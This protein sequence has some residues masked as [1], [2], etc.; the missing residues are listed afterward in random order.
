MSAKYNPLAVST[1]AYREEALFSP[2]NES[3]GSPAGQDVSAI[4]VV[5]FAS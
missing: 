2:G 5:V 3:D 1:M 4:V